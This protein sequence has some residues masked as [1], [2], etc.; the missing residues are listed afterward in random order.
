V[1]SQIRRR[2]ISQTVHLAE[3]TEM[4]PPGGF[5]R[6]RSADGVG[7]DTVLP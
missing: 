7:R 6:I 4:S 3:G 2:L 5:G 1:L